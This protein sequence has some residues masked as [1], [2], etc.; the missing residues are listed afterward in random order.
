MITGASPHKSM[1]APS[2]PKTADDI[3]TVS[4]KTGRARRGAGVAYIKMWIEED[5]SFSI[6]CSVIPEDG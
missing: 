6:M 4:P 1:K 2:N 3:K 5:F